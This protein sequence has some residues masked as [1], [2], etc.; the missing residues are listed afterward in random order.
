[1]Q[2]F[3]L[4]AESI[5]EMEE[6][7]FVIEHE[8]KKNSLIHVYIKE[9]VYVTKIL[10]TLKWCDEQF[11]QIE[12]VFVH[13]ILVQKECCKKAFNP[14]G[15]SCGGSISDPNKFYHY[16][17]VCEYEEDAVQLQEITAVF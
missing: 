5:F 15:V 7:D 12:P 3:I 17:I 13:P 16:E 10:M 6:H 11:T 9:P 8:G 1:M 2:K 4:L 14:R